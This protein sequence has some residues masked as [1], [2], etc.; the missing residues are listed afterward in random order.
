MHAWPPRLTGE[1]RCTEIQTKTLGAVRQA[2]GDDDDITSDSEDPEDN[3]WFDFS[4]TEP[5]DADESDETETTDS[6]PRDGAKGVQ[7]DVVDPEPEADQAEPIGA[8]PEP[9][10]AQGVQPNVADPEPGVS[11][12]THTKTTRMPMSGLGE[13]ATT[14]NRLRR[15]SLLLQK[16]ESHNRE[17]WTRILRKGPTSWQPRG[18]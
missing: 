8:E 18:S 2:V 7:P 5:D 10:D 6:E 4:D 1:T 16:S 3:P 14:L 15:I 13:I 17:E 9:D 11:G 12:V